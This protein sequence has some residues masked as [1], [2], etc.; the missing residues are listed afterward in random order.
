MNQRIAFIFIIYEKARR[1]VLGILDCIECDRIP[2]P[3]PI[4]VWNDVDFEAAGMNVR[5]WPAINYRSL[6]Y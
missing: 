2:H 1:L 5:R 6:E 3:D 4:Y